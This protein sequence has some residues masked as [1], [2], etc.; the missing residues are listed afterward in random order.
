[1]QKE[2]NKEI[3]DYTESIFFGLS[4]R[5]LVFSAIA[6]GVAIGLYFLLKNRFGTETVSWMCV[7]GAAPF[8]LMGF[9]TYHGMKA[10]RFIKAFVISKILSARKL[11][12]VSKNIYYEALKN[13]R[14]TS[15]R[16]DNAKDSK[17]DT[18]TAGGEL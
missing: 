1:M 6:V 13:N 17:E 18:K 16:L 8:A 9:F 4:I 14:K 15:R 7:L 5:Q 11:H 3:R 2:I 10:E 12:F